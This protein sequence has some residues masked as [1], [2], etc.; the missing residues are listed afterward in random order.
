MILIS[1]CS[2]TKGLKEG[3]Y[4][5]YDID[6]HGNKLT[7]KNDLLSLAR[8]DPNTR[9]PL[10]NT[11]IGV[12]LYRFGEWT[13]DSLKPL[14]KKARYE[15]ERLELLR[16]E[17][18]S[19][20]L[21]KKQQKRLN[22]V[23]N[24]LSSLNKKIEFGNFFM[25]TGN[26]RVILD[27]AKTEESRRQM[28]NFLLNNGFFDAKTD[29]EVKTKRK[30]AYVTYLIEE[31]SPYLVDTFYTR[32]DDENI[33]L[34]LENSANK[35]NIKLSSRY[36]Q[37][38]ITRERQRVEDILKD[39]GYYTF[40]RSYIE[41][42]VYKDTV[43]K[44]VDIEQVIRKPVFA[45]KHQVFF[46][47][48]VYF[49]IDPP[50]TEFF[51]EGK[52][53][54]Y[55]DINFEFYEDKY[56]EKIIASRI[57]LN[58]GDLYKRTDVIET[59][60]QLANLDL[61]R[62][63][64]IAFDTLGNVLR[65]KIFTQP[66]QKYL[67]TNQ[68]GASITEQ[69]PGPFFSHS[70]R[71]RNLFRGAE[72]FEFFFRAGLEGVVSA[73]GEGGVF[74]SR[75]LNTSASVIFP[76]FLFP[77]NQS[78]L[79]KF[80]RYNPNTRTLIGYNYVNRPEYIRESVNGIVAYNWNTRNLRQ[81]Y[82]FNVLDANFIRSNLNRDFR[83]LL[84][85]LQNQGNNLIN[86]FLPSYVSSISGQVIINFNQYGLFQKNR[87]SLWRI[88]L[89]SGGTTLNFFNEDFINNRNLAY[90]QFLKFQSDFRRYIPL[91]RNQTFAYRLNL[92][93]ARPYGISNGVLPYE[94]Y[95]FAGGST[96]IRAWQPR[97]LGPGSFTPETLEDGTF[98]YRFEQPADILFEGMFE[99]R[100]KLYGYFDGAFFID[101]GNS[102]TFQE[103]L[104]RPGANFEFD[105][106]WREIAVGTGLG[107]RMDFDFLVFRLDMGVKAVDPARPIGE[108]FILGN[109]F[110][111]FLGARGQTVF[112]IGIGYPF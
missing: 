95:F 42:N 89:E 14:E 96:G 51:D 39:N 41:Y 78:S 48:S 74:R 91:S 69:V 12:S 55:R 68:L 76:Q 44:K 30:K 64:N 83:Q 102:W 47:D 87:A 106:F 36:D 100:S 25:R 104:T 37:S 8:Q 103:D 3:E 1:S 73:T 62:F 105:R 27:S 72:I 75:E 111:S 80:G 16:L 57:F 71:N 34:I 110:K 45:D 18:T 19:E 108:R 65:P 22:K 84:E 112:N 46:L 66:N 109:F 24:I 99:L 35:S 70:L 38:A 53:S 61:F 6:V 32:S 9:I 85:D 40:S 94:K 26:P 97:R 15:Q 23:N 59:Q 81:Q 88:F 13:Y 92:G 31:N 50:S 28:A 52:K 21:S 77:F 60:R 49:S 107:L 58:K 33:Y 86:S 11:S 98:D 4:L 5:L 93:M 2:L 90:F 67:V 82:T 54:T 10:L 20:G 101:L 7:N 17:T 56:S 43:E 29:F 79:Q 63:V